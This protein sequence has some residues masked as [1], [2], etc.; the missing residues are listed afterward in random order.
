MVNGRFRKKTGKRYAKRKAI[1]PQKPIFRQGKAYGVKPQP[2]PTRLHTRVVFSDVRYTSIT[3]A[4]TGLS[5]QYVYR[6]NSIW[7]PD[8][9]GLGTT[10]KGWSALNA[11]Y[12]KYIVKGAKVEV[13]FDDPTADGSV[14]FVSL[15][16]RT[17]LAGIT[18]KE[19]LDVPTTYTSALN[20]S[21]SQRKKFKLYVTPWSQI[22]IS[23]MEYLTN[24]DLYAA[25]M[26]ANPSKE[27][28][29]RCGSVANNTGISTNV[30][31][32]MSLKI[33]YYVMF[34]ERNGL[35]SSSI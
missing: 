10:V 22:G 21:G 14:A 20:N 18:Y 1:R 19:I 4:S 3:S 5:D 35:A 8:Q 13:S 17:G 34:Y 25:Q 31:M 29:L 6:L 11:I 15:S 28:I 33:T 24:S 30:T 7:D 27:I 32:T 12:N 2:F 26:S 16:Q 9:T 23:K